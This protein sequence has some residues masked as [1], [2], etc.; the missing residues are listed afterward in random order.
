MK[1]RASVRRLRFIGFA[2]SAAVLCALAVFGWGWSRLRAS[3]PPL[4][5]ADQV[6]GL[7]APATLARDAQGVVTIRGASRLD[8]TRALGY[9]HG[10][11]RFFQMDLLRR[12]PA[13]ELAA[14]V[15]AA[16]VNADRSARRHGFR[17]LAESVFAQLP[18]EERTLIQAYT[19]G[20]NAG[21]ASLAARPFEYYLLRSEPAPWV[22]ADSL[23]VIYAMSLDLQDESGDFERT[24]TA[25]RD[26]YGEAAVAFFAP[27]L[28]PGDAAL[29]GTTAPLPPPPGPR[30]IDLRA[31]PAMTTADA[32]RLEGR[33]DP[34]PIGSNSFGLAGGRVAGGGA[35]VANDMHLGHAVP[36]IW[37]RASLQWGERTVTGVTLPGAPA[38]VAGSNG[39]VAWAF[40]NS[41][42][43]TV[44]LVPLDVDEATADSHY[45][46]DGAP[47][48]Y[49]VRR[50]TIQVRGGEDVIAEYRWTRW[51][52]VVG[53]NSHGKPLAL[54]WVMYDV[55]AV[56]YHLGQIEEAR[57]VDEAIAVAHRSGIPAQNILIG[58]RAGALAWTIAGR[59]PERFGFDGRFPVS[60]N[61]ERGWR[62]LLAPDRLPVVRAA[63]DGHLWTANNRLVGGADLERIGDGGYAPPV[64][65]RQIRDALALAGSDPTDR[66]TPADLL[67]IQ[68][69]DRGVWLEGWQQLLVATLTDE[70]ILGSPTRRELRDLVRT[71]EGRAAVD[72]VSY[73][74]V[75]A[76]RDAVA[77]RVLPPI[78]ARCL[79]AD[80]DFNFRTL[81]YEH[82]L[83]TL[84]TEQPLHLLRPE[85]ARWSDL[86]LAAADQVVADLQAQ[87]VPL[88][89]ATWGAR[90]TARI[91]HPL[92]RVLPE[93][94]GRHLDMP[95]EPLPGDGNLPRVQRPS[96]GASERFVVVP[97]REAEGIFHMP[98]GQSGHP[99]SPYYRAGHAAWVRGEP[100]PF[101]PGPA[102]HTL[103]LTP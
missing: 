49:D 103:T 74:L 70:V 3:L 1:P 97:G 27:R 42:A 12:Q 98:A 20:V 38:V 15:G 78:L 48:P 4:E 26:A 60:R 22:P 14:L 71:W 84:A 82:A 2:L 76:W 8:V 101:L 52:P 33:E 68:L 9:A 86:L 93:F 94:L 57:T 50:E 32:A 100:T 5:G 79:R 67:A 47:V 29:D 19:D 66:A 89:E 13:G 51:G 53:K 72:S 92:S 46:V 11:D 63:A 24:I 28:V 58:D 31:D 54:Q 80:P 69:D 21:L 83:K 30:V 73:R 10:Q 81:P 64:R 35:L 17:Q 102:A 45:L 87:G 41:Y 37:Y 36:N 59:L 56:N 44:D 6:P 55:G 62:G 43:D 99:L 7:S 65:G 34:L 23:L 40:T 88:A 85:F 61:A 16:A 91:R 18:A 96:S 90:N 75:R 39:E 25:V 77:D 95:A